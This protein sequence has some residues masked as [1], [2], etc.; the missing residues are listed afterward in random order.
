MN[1][2]APHVT[3]SPFAFTQLLSSTRRGARLARLLAVAQLRSWDAPQDLTERAEIVVAELAANAVL[4]GT[5]PGRSFRLTLALEA[6]PGL[7]RI[8]VTDARGDRWPQLRPVGPVSDASLPVGG[9][10][11]SLV[12]AL[13]DR[14]K[15]LPY[16]PSGKTV[17]AELVRRT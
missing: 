12:S 13:A 16:P 7:L 8:D 11:L 15:T 6:S 1:H 17:R 3:T 14:W 10:G 4:H 5:V 2:P 9:R